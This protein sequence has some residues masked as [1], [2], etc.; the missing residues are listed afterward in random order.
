MTETK[1]TE[2]RSATAA[3]GVVRQVVF[4]HGFLDDGTVWDSVVDRIDQPGLRATKVDLAGMGARR[5]EGGPYSLERFAADV[6]AICDSLE[7]PFVIVGHSLGAQV[8]ELVAVSRPLTTLGLVLVT[9]V[10]LRGYGAPDATVAAFRRLGGAPDAQRATRRQLTVGLSEQGLEAL[11]ARGLKADPQV[12]SGYVDAWNNGHATGHA[13]SGYR[14]P[15]L[16]IEGRQDGFITSEIISALISPR[17]ESPLNEQVCGSGH[18][19]HAEQPARVAS[20]LT[21][22]L[23]R[24]QWPVVSGSNT[25]AAV[26]PPAWTNAFAERSAAAFA[27][28]FD[29]GVVLEAT[30]LYRPVTGLKKVMSVMSTASKIYESL[31]FT[32]EAANGPRSYLEWRAR[33]FG[34]MELDGTTVLTKGPEGKIVHVAIHHRP[35]AAVLRFSSELGD[36]LKDELDPAHFYRAP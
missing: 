26:A 9:P 22:F 19:P 33:A 10:P 20:I 16:I 12:V 28:Q 36:R 15:V 2:F 27:K 23:T 1:P 32:H 18:W 11:T 13:P 17:F 24:V 7:S 25:G 4:V 31:E 5:D 3:A 21:D 6:R 30:T 29:D 8:A 34:G 14:G 35:L